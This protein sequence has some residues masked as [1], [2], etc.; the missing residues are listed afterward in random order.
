VTAFNG[1]SHADLLEIPVFH[2]SQQ[3]FDSIAKGLMSLPFVHFPFSNP[4]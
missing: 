3:A 2:S 1:L 4:T